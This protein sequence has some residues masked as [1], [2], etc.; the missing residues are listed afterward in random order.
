MKLYNGLVATYFPNEEPLE[1]KLGEFVWQVVVIS[2]S[3]VTSSLLKAAHGLHNSLVDGK[4]R[5]GLRWA[6]WWAKWFKC[7][8]G[9]YLVSWFSSTL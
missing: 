4:L 3:K 6:M 9:I 5:L 7:S 2:S 1:G 8:L